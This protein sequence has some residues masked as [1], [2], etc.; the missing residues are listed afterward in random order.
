M[1]SRVPECQGSRDSAQS[2]RILESVSVSVRK[3]QKVPESASVPEKVP[4]FQSDCK[5]ILY[6]FCH[7]LDVP[8]LNSFFWHF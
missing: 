6:C 5:K 4:K 1:N 2:A 8:Y 7:A 3:C